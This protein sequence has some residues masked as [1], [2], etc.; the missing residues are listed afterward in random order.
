MEER[1]EAIEECERLFRATRLRVST[2]NVGLARMRDGSELVRVG[3]PE[4]PELA[5]WRY[6]DVFG[7]RRRRAVAGMVTSAVGGAAMSYAPLVPVIGYALPAVGIVGLFGWAFTR[8]ARRVGVVSVPGDKHPLVVRGADLKHAV[9][10]AESEGAW[11]LRVTGVQ[12]RDDAAWWKPETRRVDR[13]LHGDAARWAAATLLPRLNAASAADRDVRAAVQLLARAG[14]AN[15]MFGEA[16]RYVLEPV[17]ALRP[18]RTEPYNLR[19]LPLVMRVALEMAAHEESE[20]RAMEGELAELERAWRDA[21]A[22]ARI[23]DDLLLPPGVSSAL[24]RL[25]GGRKHA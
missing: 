17:R 20:R 18:T 2:D 9:F 3:R 6:G 22:L 8:A 15:A 1:W 16:A 10:L 4:R 13:T 25:R 14:D 21:D 19:H 7:R 12:A 23:A 11:G 24:D 5:A